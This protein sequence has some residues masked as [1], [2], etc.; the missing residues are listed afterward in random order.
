[1]R[2]ALALAARG[3]GETAPNPVVGC[4]IARGGR[5]LAEGWHRRA[6]LAHAEADALAKLRPGQARGATC[7][8]T[9]EPCDHTGR[10]GP[11]SRALI[12]A[13]IR[14][15]V[16]AMR[17]PHDI[18][19][20]RG[21]R[22]LRRAGLEVEVGLLEDE[23]RLLNAGYLHWLATGRPRVTLKAAVSL[24]GRLATRSGDARWVTGERA[25]REGHR[26]RAVSQAVLVGGGTV[27]ADD[28]E[29]TVRLPGRR[30]RQR[31]AVVLDAKLQTPARARIVRP[32]T[33]VIASSTAP[34]KR[35]RAL[36]SKGVELL[37]LPGRSGRVEI[38]AVLD[39]LGRRGVH[40]LLVEGGSEV[41]ASFIEAGQVDRLV[42]FVA[43]L[44]LGR[45]GVPLAD[46]AGPARLAEALR[47]VDVDVRRL[48]EDVMIAGRPSG[49]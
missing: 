5:V 41:H 15:V 19:A 49:R 37:R 18:V 10:T 21:L 3:L 34:A 26:L 2:R 48:G 27:V 30:V 20:G 39:E 29:L 13:G 35:E 33:L 6:G 1:M 28:P 22:R 45:E 16:V 44:L 8:V 36:V 25:R 4:V 40:D 31:L 17:D 46:L 38:G 42:V 7:F 24:D 14:R 11:C 47:L 32:G 23:A 9:L 12:A 43:P